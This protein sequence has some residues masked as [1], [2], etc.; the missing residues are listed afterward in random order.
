MSETREPARDQ[1]TAGH[2]DPDLADRLRAVE[3]AITD[4]DVTP[5]DLS[6]PAAIEERLDRLED[7]VDDLEGRLAETEAGVEAVRGYVGSVRAVNRDVERRADAALA[8]ADADDDGSSVDPG[9]VDL[10][11]EEGPRGGAGRSGEEE[12]VRERLEQLL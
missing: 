12:S 2:D 11:G 8:A 1:P 5:A 6:E 4:A 3:R 9:D 10:P 7:R